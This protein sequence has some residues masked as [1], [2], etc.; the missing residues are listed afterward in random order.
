MAENKIKYGLK[1]VYFATLSY[2]T[3]GAPVFATPV[4]F[5]GAVSLDLSAEGDRTPFYAD[6][7]EY[8]VGNINNGY[9]GSLEMARITD[10]FRKKVLGE[11]VDNKGILVED[12][13]APAVHFALLFQF[14]GDDKATRHVLYNCTAGR[15][16]AGSE[17]KGESIDPKTESVDISASSIYCSAISKEIVKAST[18]DGSDS[19]TYNGWFSA[20][21]VPAGLPTP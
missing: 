16:S 21:Y 17:T 7:I 8:W 10:D 9:S 20:V 6:N 3:T 14:E 18:T 12:M 5:P 2:D 13:N 19:T 15:P 1:N 4:A 11:I